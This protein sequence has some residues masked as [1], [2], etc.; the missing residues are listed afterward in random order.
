MQQGAAFFTV[1]YKND[2]TV[3]FTSLFQW[4][5]WS[6]LFC[7]RGRIEIKYLFSWLLRNNL[8]GVEMMLELQKADLFETTFLHLRGYS[9]TNTKPR[10]SFLNYNYFQNINFHIL[11]ILQIIH[12]GLK[13]N[14]IYENNS[15]IYTCKILFSTRSLK[16]K[17]QRFS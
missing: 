10:A 4:R 17:L 12:W 6:A 14:I 11:H 1:L 5:K 3:R 13:G 2:V 9:A 8:L 7:C 15:K 16:K